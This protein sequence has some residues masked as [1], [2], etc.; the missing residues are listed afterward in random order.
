VRLTT[1]GGASPDWW[2]PLPAAGGAIEAGEDSAS[3][4]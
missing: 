2:I 4:R 3:S 1:E